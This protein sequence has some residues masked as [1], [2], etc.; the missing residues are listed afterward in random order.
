MAALNS[1]PGGCLCTSVRF[2]A[3]PNKLEMGVC[4]CEMCRR[5]TGGVFM[6]VACAE[7]VTVEDKSQMGT[8]QSSK[9]GQRVFCKKCGTSLFWKLTDGKHHGV[10]ASAFDDPTAFKLVRQM[11]I[12][13]KP[14]TYAFANETQ[15]LTGAELFATFY[16]GCKE[17]GAGND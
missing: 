6:M 8:Y 14:D 17:Q 12:E 1:M 9:W 15:D 5:W 16:E 2:T 7:N 3:T 11:F 13:E 4:H 10:A